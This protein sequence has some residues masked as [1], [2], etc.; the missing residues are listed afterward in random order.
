MKILTKEEANQFL[1]QNGKVIDIQVAIG[2]WDGTKAWFF[3]DDHCFKHELQKQ[4]DTWIPITMYLRDRP[5]PHVKPRPGLEDGVIS[6]IDHFM[7]VFKHECDGVHIQSEQELRD[8][9]YLNK[10]G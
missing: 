5:I 9:L 7:F 4:F 6:N 3:T 8:F 10:K 2:G 1:K